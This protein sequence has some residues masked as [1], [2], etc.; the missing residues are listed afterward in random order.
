MLVVQGS[1]RNLHSLVVEVLLPM[2]L[3][4][5]WERKDA[6]QEE[7]LLFEWLGGGLKTWSCVVSHL[8]QVWVC[9]TLHVGRGAEQS[10]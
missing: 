9:E 7:F 6:Q 3:G 2:G 4:Q 5:D 8:G 1:Q 10:L